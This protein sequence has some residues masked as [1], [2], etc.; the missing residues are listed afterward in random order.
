MPRK[1]Q[2]LRPGSLKGGKNEPSAKA[3]AGSGARFKALE[4]KLDKKGVKNPAGLAA[5]IGRA[6]F[7]KKR[8]AK[9]ALKGRK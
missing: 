9:M 5:A 2:K 4:S 1:G 6:K 3:K 8:M 7:G